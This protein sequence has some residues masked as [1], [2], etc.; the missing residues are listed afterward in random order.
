[1]VVVTPS[2][3]E[4][5]V[6]AAQ[7][8]DEAAFASLH[9]RFQRLVHG[10]VLARVPLGEVEDLVQ[11]VFVHAWQHLAAIRD[12]G[13]FGS[14]IAMIARNRATDYHRRAPRRLVPLADYHSQRKPVDP[15][16]FQVLETIRSMPDAYRDTLLLRLVE[17]LTGPEISEQTGLTPDSVRVNLHRGMKLLRERLEGRSERLEGKS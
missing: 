7:C 15:A 6:A 11:E 17:G 5:L 13:A 8:G 2:E 14:W 1:L 4:G 16:A 12:R 10:I 9:A 3:A